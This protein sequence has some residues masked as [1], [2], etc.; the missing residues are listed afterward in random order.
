[1]SQESHPD[2][3]PKDI[4]TFK[5]DHFSGGAVGAIRVEDKLVARLFTRDEL[6]EMWADLNTEQRAQLAT[7]GYEEKSVREEHLRVYKQVYKK[8]LRL[9]ILLDG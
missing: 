4:E 2:Y 9:R 1:M 3:S 5:A 7:L 8:N 6:D